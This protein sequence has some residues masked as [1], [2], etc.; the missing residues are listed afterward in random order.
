MERY[1]KSV[2]LFCGR[3][4]GSP[5]RRGAMDVVGISCVRPQKNK[6]KTQEREPSPTNR[7]INFVFPIITLSRRVGIA[8][9]EHFKPRPP[10]EVAP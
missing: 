9:A 8:P 4:Q 6:I 1:E 3:P 10:G 7:K 2:G 5:M